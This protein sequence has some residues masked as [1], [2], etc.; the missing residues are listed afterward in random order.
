MTFVGAQGHVDSR[1]SVYGQHE[2]ETRPA[3]QILREKGVTFLKRE[4]RSMMRSEKVRPISMPFLSF[5]TF[6][7][8][9]TK[10]LPN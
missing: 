4:C 9:R 1:W 3:F 8:I 10:G 2:R 6:Y 7:G 5:F